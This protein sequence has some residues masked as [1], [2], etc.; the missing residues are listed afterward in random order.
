MEQFVTRTARM[1]PFNNAE[2][3]GWSAESCIGAQWVSM[4]SWMCT[5]PIAMSFVHIYIPR[6]IATASI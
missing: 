4:P 6:Y 2:I 1:T 5:P 3:T